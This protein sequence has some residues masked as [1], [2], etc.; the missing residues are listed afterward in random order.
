MSIQRS[1]RGQLLTLLASSILLIVLIA[2]FSFRLLSQG[3]ADYRDLLA[4][5]QAESSLIDQ[6]NLEFKS[7][8]QEWKNVLLRGKDPEALAK[9][10]SQFEEKETRVNQ[11]LQQL[12]ELAGRRPGA[13]DPRSQR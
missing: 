4:S 3:V 6:S 8:V 7:Q 1:L 9:Y 12:A 10:W 13:A 5:T 11:I 2:L